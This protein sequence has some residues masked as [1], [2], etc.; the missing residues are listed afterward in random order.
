VNTHRDG[1]KKAVLY[2]QGSSFSCPHKEKCQR[3]WP[4]GNFTFPLWFLFQQ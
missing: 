1:L 4:P 3:H 2:V